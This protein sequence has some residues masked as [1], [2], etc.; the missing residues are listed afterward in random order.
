LVL[1]PQ[2]AILPLTNLIS[3]AFGLMK[4]WKSAVDVDT[5]SNKTQM[6][7]FLLS[8]IALFTNNSFNFLEYGGLIKFTPPHGDK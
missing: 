6:A 5:G 8:R 3:F 7:P 1:T 4:S 2:N